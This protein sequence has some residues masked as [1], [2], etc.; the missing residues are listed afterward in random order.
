MFGGREHLWRTL[1]YN[2]VWPMVANITATNIP[3]NPILEPGF[4]SVIQFVILLLAFSTVVLFYNSVIFPN[5]LEWLIKRYQVVPSRGNFVII[6]TLIVGASLAG[7]CISIVP[8]FINFSYLVTCCVIAEVLWGFVLGAIFLTT[9]DVLR[10]A[11][12]LFPI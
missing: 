5:W 4:Q 10:I 12:H 6:S 9:L 2:T 11:S 8:V 3:G 7:S 1:K